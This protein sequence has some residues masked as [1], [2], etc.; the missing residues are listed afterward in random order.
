MPTQILGHSLVLFLQTALPLTQ[1][2]RARLRNRPGFGGAA[3]IQ[4]TP[5]IAQPTAP[6][7]RRRQPGQKLVAAPVAKALVLGP[8]DRVRLRQD[9]SGDVVVVEVLVL[10]GVRVHL[11]A[12]HREHRHADQ[13][14][15]RTDREHVPE[16]AREGRL[17]TL[18]KPRNRAVIRPLVRGDHADRASSTHARSITRDERRPTA[19]A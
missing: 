15:I 1:P 6:A 18:A 14:G 9:R 16:K 4:P 11:R 10:R 3:V 5:G 19:R 2:G 8:V 7:L 12:I 13:P 17:V